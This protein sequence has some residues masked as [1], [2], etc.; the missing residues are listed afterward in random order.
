MIK[1][2]KEYVQVKRAAVI[3]MKTTKVYILSLINVN[4]VFCWKLRVLKNIFIFHSMKI[5]YWDCQFNLVS[6]LHNFIC[7]LKIGH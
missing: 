3:I 6:S 4:E 1:F 5:L 7:F 2:I